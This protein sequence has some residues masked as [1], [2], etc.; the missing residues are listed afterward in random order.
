MVSRAGL[1]VLCPVL[2]QWEGVALNGRGPQLPV[3]EFTPPSGPVRPGEG[4]TVHRQTVAGSRR[5]DSRDDRHMSRH[6]TCSQSIYRE[7]MQK[8]PVDVIE[9][10][11]IVSHVSVLVNVQ[12]L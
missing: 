2:S 10:V 5:P 9:A 7:D 12:L 1:T 6:G 8:V 3:E 11:T 4:G